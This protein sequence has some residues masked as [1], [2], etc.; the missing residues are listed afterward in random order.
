MVLRHTFEIAAEIESE[1]EAIEIVRL[2]NESKIKAPFIIKIG[3][4]YDDD[5]VRGLI[6]KGFIER[7]GETEDGEPLYRALDRVL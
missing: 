6:E 3:P 2:L 5:F 4:L 7:A 1:E